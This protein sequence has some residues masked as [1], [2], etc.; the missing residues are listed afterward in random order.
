MTPMDSTALWF[1]KRS[2]EKNLGF[3]LSI[4][5]LTH[6]NGSAALRIN[7]S[8]QQTYMHGFIVNF[9]AGLNLAWM[10]SSSLNAEIWWSVPRDFAKRKR[11]TG[12]W[13]FLR[14]LLL[15]SLLNFKDMDRRSELPIFN[16]SISLWLYTFTPFILWPNNST[17]AGAR[18]KYY[19]HLTVM[20]RLRV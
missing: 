6:C 5:L 9:R 3:L 2:L 1:R 14:N 11:L 12:L 13:Y 10:V 7:Q 18:L 8:I 20:S 17:A 16:A 4:H 15:W 19:R